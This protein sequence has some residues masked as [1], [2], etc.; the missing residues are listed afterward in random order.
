MYCW[1]WTCERGTD[2]LCRWKLGKKIIVAGPWA[3]QSLTKV[4]RKN[5]KIVFSSNYST[6]VYHK[7]W[8]WMRKVA[9]IE[10]RQRLLSTF[11]VC[12]FSFEGNVSFEW[13][14]VKF[15]PVRFLIY[16][17]HKFLLRTCFNYTNCIRVVCE[18]KYISNWS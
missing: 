6:K 12:V 14:I 1:N 5:L 11:L 17:M 9:S 18:L 2:V 15:P 16:C 8:L 3:F 4:H 7:V 10:K 13:I